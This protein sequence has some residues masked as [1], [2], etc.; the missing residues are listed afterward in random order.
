MIST[1]M[2]RIRSMKLGPMF[3]LVVFGIIVSITT[4]SY[5]YLYQQNKT[6]LEEKLYSKGKSILDFADVLLESRNEKI[7][8][9]ESSEVPHVLCVIQVG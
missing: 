4:S 7:F 8:S 6:S 5:F 9:G 3:A 1:I 2:Y